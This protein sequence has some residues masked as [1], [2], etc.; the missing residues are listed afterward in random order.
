MPVAPFKVKAVYDYKSAEPDDL[1]FPN[2]QIITVTAEED[3]DWYSGEF[4]DGTGRKLDGIF[5]KNFVEKYEPEIPLR[6]SRPARA[7]KDADPTPGV[8]PVPAATQVPELG[9][10][11]APKVQEADTAP[12]I[13][14]RDVSHETVEPPTPTQPTQGSV[15]RSASSATTKPPIQSPKPTANKPPPP[16]VAEKTDVGSFKDRMAMFNKP[17]APPIAPFKPGGAGS[18]ASGFIKKPFVA[19]P[20]SKNAYVPPPREPPPQKVYRRE[21]DPG[22]AA[23][24]AN[25]TMTVVSPPVEPDATGDE[26]QPKPT[27]LKDRIAL[28]QKQQLEQARRAEGASKKEKPKKPPKKHAEV[29]E[30]TEPSGVPSRPSTDRIGTG[31]AVGKKSVDFAD[32]ESGPLRGHA[33]R[34]ASVHPGLATPPQ[35]SRELVSDTNDADD[36]TEEAPDTSAGEERNSTRHAPAGTHPMA[37]SRQGVQSPPHEGEAEEEEDDDG[38]DEEEIEEEEV[39]PEV[40]RRMEIRER[41]A[42][43]SGG[44]GMMGMFGPAG[45]MPSAGTTRKPKPSSEESGRR[46]SSGHG[47]EEVAAHAPPV[48]V[49]A[50]PGMFR[51]RSPEPE[52]EDVENDTEDPPSRATPKGATAPAMSQEEIEVPAPPKRSSTGRS[53]PPVPQGQCISKNAHERE[54]ANK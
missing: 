34:Q 27:S 23:E 30:P 53:A 46:V 54:R 31:D 18:G 2:G 44:M 26:D 41:M 10:E 15:Q 11:P 33:G 13:S 1:N 29:E 35:P 19:P 25:E 8:V 6:P 7:K 37:H 5:P 45:G 17:A 36:D 52:G 48:P 39:D 28:L 32:D 51:T 3:D 21:E 50:L 22:L 20:P 9:Q 40:R 47:Q 4:V 14:A 43:M 49:M 16:Q 42:K 12:R 24:Q 38:A